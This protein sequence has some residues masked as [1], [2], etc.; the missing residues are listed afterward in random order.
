[1]LFIALHGI[2]IDTLSLTVLTVLQTLVMLYRAYENLFRW[3]FKLEGIVWKLMIF[4]FFLI[5]IALIPGLIVLALGFA[6]SFFLY[7]GVE[8]AATAYNEGISKGFSSAY[9]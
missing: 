9:T 3:Y 2:I 1:M 5:M 4:P 8:T 6:I 7:I